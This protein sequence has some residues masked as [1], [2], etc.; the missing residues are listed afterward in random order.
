MD[1]VG[2]GGVGRGERVGKDDGPLTGSRRDTSS[3]E[4]SRE[5]G[6]GDRELL[7]LRAVA[8][9]G[10]C[11]DGGVCDSCCLCNLSPSRLRQSTG[12]EIT[13]VGAMWGLPSCPVEVAN[14]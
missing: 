2:V 9:V 6:R 5:K 1:A 7:G 10:L 14:A 11:G 3:S 13:R 4:F 12:V 8:I